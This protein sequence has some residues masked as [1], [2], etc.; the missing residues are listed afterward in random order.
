MSP[1][2]VVDHGVFV[3]QGTF[4]VPPAAALEHIYLA[5]QQLR[6]GHQE[7]ALAEARRAVELAPEN[8]AALTILGDSYIA[9]GT[10]QTHKPRIGVLSR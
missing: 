7:D 4:D 2:A 3:Y 6:A 1:V 10:P 5:R 8:V 9:L